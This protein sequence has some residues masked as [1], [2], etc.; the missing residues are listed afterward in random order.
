MK[1]C[2]D[3]AGVRTAHWIEGANNNSA[4]ILKWADEA[5]Y[6]IVSKSLG[7]SRGEGND[8]HDNKE[9]LERFL[10]NRNISNY[11]FERFHNFDREYRIHASKN[12]CFYTC[13]KMLKNE[14]KGKP[15]AWQRHEDNC[16][17]IIEENPLF[18]RP[19]NWDRIVGDCVK[20]LKALGLDI[21]GFDVR[22]Q[23][24]KDA[25]GNPR[26]D[27][28]YIIIESNSACSFGE[29]TEQKYRDELNRL[30]ADKSI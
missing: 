7:G 19:I 11:I 18:D 10:N 9:S 21:A 22:V 6:P 25:K 30:I 4:V 23:S 1:R 24:T 17:W 16:V 5:E 27:V 13:R 26:K 15:N 20:A 8:K 28:D 14:H 3:N 29:K 12:G 2:F